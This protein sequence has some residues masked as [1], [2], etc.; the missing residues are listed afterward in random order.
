[1]CQ[2]YNTHLSAFD[3]VSILGSAAGPLLGGAGSILG[4]A[5]SA[6]A[7]PP[8]VRPSTNRLPIITVEV[9]VLVPTDTCTSE[10]AMVEVEEIPAAM[11]RI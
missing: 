2:N 11:H 6:L 8:R 7:P 9:C 1:M 5:G 4:G 3:P 10:W